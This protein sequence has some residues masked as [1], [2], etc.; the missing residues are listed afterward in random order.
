MGF[1]DVFGHESAVRSLQKALASDQLPGTYLLTGPQGIGKTTLALAF[2]E[3]AAC[4]A[5][6]EEPFDSCGECDSCRRARA[7][8]HPEIALIPPVGDQTQI[9]QFWD[10]DGRPPGILQHSLHFAPVIGRRRV[11]IIERAD[12]LNEAA[13]N[14][15]LKVLEEPPPYAVF[16]LL[17]THAGRLLPT[18][19]SRSQLVRLLPASINELAHFL[20]EATG[21]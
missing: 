17:A 2:A 5:P 4:L 1:R 6:I 14:S 9:W 16:V 11:Y 8:D 19:L 12:T 20:E 3:A 21:L 15:L 10:R 7:G 18:V 13:A